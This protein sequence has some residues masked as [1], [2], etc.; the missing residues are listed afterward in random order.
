MSVT[1]RLLLVVCLPLVGLTAACKTGSN[2]ES[3]PIDQFR[4]NGRNYISAGEAV[5]HSDVGD[6]VGT[7]EKGLPSAAYNCTYYILEDGMGSPQV[8]SK[9]YAVHGENPA[10]FLAVIE[11]GSD[12]VRLYQYDEFKVLG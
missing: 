12:K 2:C 3:E 7:I 8:G 4:L 11:P 5:A 10:S 6:E 9:V 1:A